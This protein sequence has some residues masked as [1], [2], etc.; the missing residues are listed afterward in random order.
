METIDEKLVS[1]SEAK[2]IIEGR[3]KEGE[4]KYEQKNALEILRKFVTITPENAKKL[5]EELRKIPSLRDRHIVAIIN[6]LPQDRDDLRAVL[7]KEYNNFTEED[8]T[9]ILDAVKKF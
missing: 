4:L 1:D 7:H 5:E 8:L 6:F 2:E 9:L 3:A